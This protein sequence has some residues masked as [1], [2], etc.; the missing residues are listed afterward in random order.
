ME[1][2]DIV[3]EQNIYKLKGYVNRPGFNAKN[4]MCCAAFHSAVFQGNKEIC[5]ILLKH[6]VDIDCLNTLG[7][8]PLHS[9]TLQGNLEMIRYLVANGASIDKASNDGWSP[10]HT[11]AQMGYVECVQYFIDLGIDI[12]S[13]N[14]LGLGAIHLAVSRN[15]IN[16]VELLVERGALNKGEKYSYTP[17]HVASLVGSIRCTQILYESGSNID[18]QNGQG[19]TPLHLAAVEGELDVVKLLIDI[20][21]DTTIKNFDEETAFDVAKDSSKVLLRDAM[22]LQLKRDKSVDNLIHA[23]KTLP[24][25]SPFPT[26]ITIQILE[27]LAE[28]FNKQELQ[29]IFAVLLDQSKLKHIPQFKLAREFLKFCRESLGNKH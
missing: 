21:A 26:E 13:T 4:E 23:A 14:Y 5:D 15:K 19:N 28:G 20:Q 18:S 17:L 27:I 6:Q 24:W 9:V 2:L 16:V 10:L 1:L 3:R 22:S 7:F 11:S 8:T 12:H 25:G 29:V